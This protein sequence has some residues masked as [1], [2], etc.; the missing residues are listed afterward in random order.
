MPHQWA[1]IGQG[2]ALYRDIFLDLSTQ[3]HHFGSNL[4]NLVIHELA[5]SMANHIQ[6][7]P[8]DHHADF[9]FAENLIKNYWPK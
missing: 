2:R 3:G 8:N 4:K 7:R 6:W 1:K 9:K 5:H